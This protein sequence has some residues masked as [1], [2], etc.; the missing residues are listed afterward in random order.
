MKKLRHLLPMLLA[1]VMLFTVAFAAACKKDNKDKEEEKAEL[2]SISVDTSNVRKEY[3]IGEEFSSEGIVVKANIKQPDAEEAEEKTLS[4]SEYVL[5][6]SAYV[7][8][9]AGTYTIK[10]SYTLEEVTKEASFDV[11]V[12]A[13]MF[14]G[15]QVTLK[16][17]TKDKY[18]L[19]KDITKANIDTTKI[20]VRE[21]DENGVV[22]DELITDYTVELYNG[23]RKIELDANG[24]ARV[25]KGGTYQIWA[26]KPSSKVPGYTLRGFVR[27]FVLNDI[28]NFKVNTENAVF[29]QDADRL[30]K[31]TAD[32]TYTL[33][34][35]NGT[36]ETLTSKD[37]V[38]TGF[39]PKIGGAATATVTYTTVD[40]NGDKIEKTCQ[41][42]FTI[43][44]SYS[45]DMLMFNANSYS[46]ESDIVSTREIFVATDKEGQEVTD[47]SLGYIKI[48]A[49]GDNAV[50]ID[51]SKSSLGTAINSVGLNLTFANRLRLLKTSTMQ[52]RSIQ[53]QI[54]GKAV[55]TVV[56]SSNDAST[57]RILALFDNEYSVINEDFGA[58]TIA[59]HTF[60]VNDAGIYY[61]GSLSD[62][63]SI[64]YIS[65]EYVD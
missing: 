34:Y 8:D 51:A 41:V 38:I 12:Y 43:K 23:N 56:A 22:I 62:D 36:T 49:D 35:K 16:E 32:W 57:E 7:K 24:R 3:F 52:A 64:Y 48:L 30:D 55:I 1:A 46:Q 45:P 40:A 28:T 26:S 10:V 50:S 27:I 60:T 31:I 54:T 61:L 53:M 4:A 58:T 20:E 2:I 21:V 6:S 25:D 9:T 5:D 37:V 65:V 19:N 13:Q 47:G 63:M 11:K 14:E 18:E 15:L 39:N 44:G 59:M 42:P 33:T 17:G 29:E